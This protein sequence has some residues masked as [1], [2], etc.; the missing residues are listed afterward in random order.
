MSR[1][2]D[3]TD[4]VHA[5]WLCD[6]RYADLQALMADLERLQCRCERSTW[7]RTKSFFGSLKKRALSLRSRRKSQEMAEL[8]A[9]REAEWPSEDDPAPPTGELPAF[10][11]PA[12]LGPN[13]AFIP[14]LAASY[15]FASY[16]NGELD[17][18]PRMDL[19]PSA[20]TSYTHLFGFGQAG[21]DVNPDMASFP[22]MAGQPQAQ[23]QAPHFY[24]LAAQ[25]P[26]PN[27]HT[28]TWYSGPPTG[29]FSVVSPVSPSAV[30]AAGSRP[31]VS[32][33]SSISSVSSLRIQPWSRSLSLVSPQ[34]SISSVSS[35]MLTNAITVTAP[36]APIFASHTTSS[37]TEYGDDADDVAPWDRPSVTAHER[38]WD[39]TTTAAEVAELPDSSPGS[40]SKPTHWLQDPAGGRLSELEAFGPFSK[41]TMPLLSRHFIQIGPAE[42][43]ELAT[44]ANVELN[45]EHGWQASQMELQQDKTPIAADESWSFFPP[46]P[47]PVRPGPRPLTSHTRQNSY[48][49]TASTVLDVLISEDD[50][51]NDALESTNHPQ[52]LLQDDAFDELP[53]QQKTAPSKPSPVK[54][55][56]TQR[57]PPFCR[58]CNFFP[59][60]GAGQHRKM[61]KH[62]QTDGHRRKTGE[63]TGAEREKHACWLC[64]ATYNREDNLWQHIKNLH[65]VQRSQKKLMWRE[66]GQSLRLAV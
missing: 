61:K 12:E 52:N 5:R 19:Y 50:Q 46:Q 58:P 29:S 34:S 33:Q 48:D 66:L 60:A 51:D 42:P 53:S 59:A 44:E 11:K 6:Q 57:E 36:S 55:Q 17:T 22:Q 8:D 37:P 38:S 62:K 28:T 26:N 7:G 21:Y 18:A 63:D 43:L 4:C 32:P 35:S 10:S 47:A 20:S 31:F 2:H 27:L 3:P 49:S 13:Q 41:P 40:R 30:S 16:P 39:S 1:P 45:V 25:A 56:K 24:E 23:A 54:R 9:G 15:L 65:G 14:E 64:P